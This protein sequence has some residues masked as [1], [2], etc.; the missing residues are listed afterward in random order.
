ML[1]KYS[2]ATMV[3]RLSR[4]FFR[5]VRRVSVVNDERSSSSDKRN[6]RQESIQRV[7]RTRRKLWKSH[8]PGNETNDGSSLTRDF[9]R[10]K[11]HG[12]CP[13]VPFDNSDEKNCLREEYRRN[14]V[15][16][17]RFLLP[18]AIGRCTFFVIGRTVMPGLVC[19]F[20]KYTLE[21]KFFSARFL[22]ELNS[23]RFQRIRLYLTIISGCPGSPCRF[24]R[25]KF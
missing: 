7:K 5:S 2:A 19:S 22:V 1:T 15:V 11:L 10:G 17:Y 14:D 9:A 6:R 16:S 24:W 4:K 13:R 3:A 23:N 8:R 20:D 21:C 18:L 25:F 12:C